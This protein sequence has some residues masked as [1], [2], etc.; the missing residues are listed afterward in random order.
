MTVTALELCLVLLALSWAAT[1]AVTRHTRT[2]LAVIALGVSIA[3]LTPVLEAAGAWPSNLADT[4]IA[5]RRIAEFVALAAAVEALGGLVLLTTRHKL[6]TRLAVLPTPSVWAL[7]PF[8][9]HVMLVHGPRWDLTL[10][11][12]AGWG[13]ALVSL[14]ATFGVFS[15]LRQRSMPLA[16]EA[17]VIL[18]SVA[19]VLVAVAM[20][21]LDHRQAPLLPFEPLAMLGSV[22]V[23]GTL[24]LIGWRRRNRLS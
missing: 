17:V 12:A 11:A 7:P 2:G 23:F 18:R 15:L 6:A 9:A 21:A 1:V 16:Y 8:L 24:M 3:V 22:V 20:A 5:N 13:I 10:L 19:L 14:A 4:L